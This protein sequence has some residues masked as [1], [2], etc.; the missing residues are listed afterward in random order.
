MGAETGGRG[1]GDGTGDGA[2]IGAGPGEW[3]GRWP[4]CACVGLV[5]FVRVG[6]A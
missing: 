5:S 1:L 6:L 2:C 3:D 4:G